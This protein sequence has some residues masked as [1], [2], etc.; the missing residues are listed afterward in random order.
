M[1]LSLKLYLNNFG[2]YQANHINIMKIKF[3][4]YKLNIIPH[5]IIHFQPKYLSERARIE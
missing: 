1:N 3:N 2:Q 5:L 4:K